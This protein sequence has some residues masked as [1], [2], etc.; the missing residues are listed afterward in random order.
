MV[1]KAAGLAT[2]LALALPA[3]AGAK[4][5]APNGDYSGP[6][7][8]VMQVS[9]KKIDIIAFN[10][11][12]RKHPKLHGRTSLNEIPLRKTSKGYKF[13]IKL[14]GI[15][16]YSDGKA[17]ENGFTSIWGQFGRKGKSVHGRFQTSTRRC[18]PTGKLKWKAERESDSGGSPAR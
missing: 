18:G 8:L 4:V 9:D 6:R 10:F 15:V 3:G 13:S 17:D 14:F 5:K 2:V 12:C 16:S 11:P 7:E 1:K